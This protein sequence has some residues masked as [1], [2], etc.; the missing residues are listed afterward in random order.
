MKNK[1]NYLIDILRGIASIMVALFHFNE[2]R[3]DR[4]YYEIFIKYGALGVP[5]FFVISGYCIFNAANS[6]KNIGD[7]YLKRIFRIYPVY[8]FSLLLVLFVA[9]FQKV[10]SGNN[11]VGVLPK[12]FGTI[13]NSVLILYE[14]LTTVKPI[15]W[16]YW[17]LTYELF[18]YLSFSIYFLLNGLKKYLWVVFLLVLSLF[19]LPLENIGILFFLKFIGSFGLGI[20]VR[21]LEKN[22]KDWLALIIVFLSVAS[23]IINC[24]N[25]FKSISNNE[26]LFPTLSIVTG[27]VILEFSKYV[28]GPS[29]LTKLGEVS[30]SLY[31]I[32]VPL[33]VY[34]INRYF[35]HFAENNIYTRFLFD[36]FN[37]F[38]CLF[39][40]YTVYQFIEIRFIT[41]G[42]RVLKNIG[43]AKI[44]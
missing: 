15:N 43:F 39:V 20:G 4:S 1:R 17:T 31:L 7:F 32:H 37:L 2:V 22:K 28:N 19:Y 3:D 30:Y 9:L 42:K 40:S 14:P 6:T 21:M 26:W 35:I 24:T 11:S 18:Y 33:G 36:I 44:N 29:I 10:V 34:V 27:L 12:S 13:I 25:L 38:V 5:M 16:V 23:L 41:L 8:W